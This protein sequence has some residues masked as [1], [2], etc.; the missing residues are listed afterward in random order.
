MIEKEYRA[1]Q[2][3]FS[4]WLYRENNKKYT[5]IRDNMVRK[6]TVLALKSILKDV[7]MKEV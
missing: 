7:Y 1:L 5:N 2:N 4:N 6:N 3:R